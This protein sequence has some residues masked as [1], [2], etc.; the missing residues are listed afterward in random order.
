M[1]FPL[2]TNLMTTAALLI[3]GNEILSGRTHDKNLPY[4]ATFLNDLGIRLM[5][6]RVVADIEEDISTAVNALRTRYDY[7]FTTGGIGPTHDDITTQSVAK[8][9]GIEVERNAEALALL[10]GYYEPDQLN[11]ARLTMADIPVGARLI[12]NPVST[13]P[14]FIVEN[15]YVM[16]GVPRIMQAMLDNVKTELKGGT[17]MLSESLMV[18]RQ[19]GDLA[20]AMGEL[21]A[22]YDGLE[23]GSYPQ[24][25]NNT[26]CTNIVLRTHDDMQLQEA[27]AKMI[28]I[29]YGMGIEIE[30]T[31]E[32]LL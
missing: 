23:I 26:L 31:N 2:Y 32:E 14:G 6:C 1:L 16:A 3:I 21:E 7:V 13:A 20:D 4:L 19:E 5:E 8:A 30:G 28:G 22:Q 27:T 15:V 24:I 9:F 17:P 29:L 12:D 25:R 11:E 18:M 10:E